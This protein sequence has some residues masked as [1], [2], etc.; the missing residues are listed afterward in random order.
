[1]TSHF[2]DKENEARREEVT[3]LRSVT[4]WEWRTQRSGFSRSR[5]FHSRESERPGQ[6]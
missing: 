2:T 5:S 6:V 3:G 4:G 1:M